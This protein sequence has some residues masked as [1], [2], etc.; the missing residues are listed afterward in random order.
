MKRPALSANATRMFE[1]R[2]EALLEWER[3]VR[4]EIPAAVDLPHPIIIDTFPGLYDSLVEAISAEYPRTS[5]IATTTIS[6]E[7]GAER[8][9]LTGYDAHSVITE[10]ELMRASVVDVLRRND[11]ELNAIEID[12]LHSSFDAAIREGVTSFALAESVLR[13]R[14]IAMSIHELRLPLSTASVAAS[15]LHSVDDMPRTREL[16]AL[17][18]ENLELVE[19]RVQ[20]LLGKLV[21]HTGERLQLH[22]TNWDVLRLVHEV[23]Y[24][25][26][27]AHGPRFEIEGMNVR[28][29]WDRPVMRR[30]VESM[31]DNAL[32]YSPPGMPIRLHVDS[33]HERMV[34]TVH[35]E[36]AAIPSER[37]ES[38]FQV[39]RRALAGKQAEPGQP[40]PDLGVPYVR[41]VAESHGGSV[42]IES[43]TGRGTTCIIDLPI[44]SRPFRN[45]PTMGTDRY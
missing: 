26:S 39:Y 7:H 22:V 11:V 16:T 43:L 24:Q 5:A 31:L 12:I 32:R 27:Q 23:A 9:R 42:G 10:Y 20:D 44:D 40:P 34:L 19:R 37:I 41:S 36:G 15:I 29:Y 28:G 4:V 6:S 21:F 2:S 8:A 30:A 14:S 33:L 13:E 25:Y 38:V 35:N 18:I 1:L 17:L 45:S 3:R